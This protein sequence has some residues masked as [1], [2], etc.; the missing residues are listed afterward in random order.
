M[1]SIFMP[2]QGKTGMLRVKFRQVQLSNRQ[3]MGH[4]QEYMQN[5]K[6]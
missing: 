3:R 1:S 4:N 2:L 6:I 5:D